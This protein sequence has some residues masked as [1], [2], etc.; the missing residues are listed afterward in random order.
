MRCRPLS[1][2]EAEFSNREIV[3]ILDKK[4]VILL[5]PFEYNGHSEVFKNRSRE[6]HYAFDYAFDSSCDQVMF[7]LIQAGSSI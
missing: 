5:D 2:K 1:I 6:S 7:T 3:K 4:L